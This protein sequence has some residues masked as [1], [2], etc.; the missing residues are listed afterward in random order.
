LGFPTTFRNGHI[1]TLSISG[2]KFN[3]TNNNTV[4]DPDESGLSGW[5]IELL[6]D[7]EVIDTIETAVDGTYSFDYLAPGSYTVREVRQAGWIQTYPPSG[8]HS[9]N[10]VDADSTGNDFGNHQIAASEDTEPPDVLSFDFDPKAVDTSASS[11]EITVTTRLTDDLSGFSSATVRFESPSDSQSASVSLSSLDRISGDELNGVYEDKMTLPQY[12]EPGTWKLDYI[13]FRDNVGNRKQL[14]ED[15]VAALGFPTEFEVESVGDAEPPDILSFDF[16][17]KAV[18]TSTSSQ[19]ITA[20]TRLTDDLSGLSSASVR[21]KSPSGGQSASVSLSPNDRI[22]GDE[23]DGVY[24][25]EMTLPRYSEPGTWKLDYISLSDNVENR[26]R[27]SGDD[28]A[29]F[30]FPTT[31]RNGH[32][33]ALSISGMKFND[34]NNNSAKD[35]DESGLPGWTIE[36]LLDGEVIDT[37]EPPSDGTY[38]FDHLAPGSYTVREVRQAGWVQTYPPGGSHSVNL[39]DAD[40]TGNDFGNHQIMSEDTE[41]PDI[42]SFD[43]DPRAINTSTL[44]QEITFTTRLT[45]DLSGLD[46]AQARF[47]SP[48]ESQSVSVSFTSSDRISGNELDGVYSDSMTL[49]Q[50]SE[51]GTWELDYV[52]LY[53][54]VGNRKQLSKDDMN[55]LNKVLRFARM[56]DGQI[57]INT[58]T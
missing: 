45:D 42:L 28:A 23:L 19:E 51:P 2:M 56:V 11:Q 16:D 52:S 40:S 10:L 20:A 31:F 54:E 39:V 48:S 7:G 47:E 17:P 25:D 24:E 34:L 55:M 58:K 8:S 33:G 50:Y 36:L 32:S 27:L 13:S 18:D 12:S 46:R 37:I 35:P 30:G 26:K 9:V 1:G 57:I 38:S 22:S 49:P 14:F 44:S 6:F 41:P 3:D 5:R 15:D 21:F 29:A 43:F 4:K 53:D